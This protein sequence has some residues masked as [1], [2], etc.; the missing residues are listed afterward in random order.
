MT[1]STEV[2]LIL[3]TNSLLTDGRMLRSTCGMITRS[4]VCP[5]DIPMLIAPS[6][7]PRSIEMMPPRTISAI[8]APVLIDTIRMPDGISAKVWPFMA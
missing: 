8:Y 4:M 5:C 3:I 2:S 6:N 1:L 7:W